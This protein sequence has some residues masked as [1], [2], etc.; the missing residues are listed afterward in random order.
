MAHSGF[1][2]FMCWCTGIQK[3]LIHTYD[4]HNITQHIH[5]KVVATSAWNTVMQSTVL[6][7]GV[8]VKFQVL[9]KVTPH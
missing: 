6:Y 9:W 5:C 3:F 2:E 8:L 4:L 1:A 7:V